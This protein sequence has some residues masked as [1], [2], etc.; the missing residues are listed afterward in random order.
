M[1]QQ[2]VDLTTVPQVTSEGFQALTLQVSYGLIRF[3]LFFLFHFAICH[4]LLPQVRRSGWEM[5]L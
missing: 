1:T 3:C 2:G 5:M 4:G